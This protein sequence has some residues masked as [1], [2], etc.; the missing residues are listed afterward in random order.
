MMNFA[1]L[2]AMARCCGR[3]G[4]PFANQP[5]FCNGIWYATNGYVLVRYEDDS[6]DVEG[7]DI[8]S[9]P[10]VIVKGSNPKDIVKESDFIIAELKCLPNCLF[11]NHFGKHTKNDDLIID[12][13][14]LKKACDVFKACGK[15]P[16]ISFYDNKAHLESDGI[17]VVVAGMVVK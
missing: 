10:D 5:F 4:A 6:L 1:M 16:A 8:R 12:E 15:H 11:D 9:V 17:H 7:L 3:K 13:C 2:K 14:L